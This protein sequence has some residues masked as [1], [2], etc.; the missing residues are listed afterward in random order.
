MEDGPVAGL[1]VLAGG[2]S[3]EHD[4][5]LLSAGEMLGQLRRGG[6][7]ARPVLID[8]EGRWHFGGPDED[9]AALSSAAAARRGAPRTLPAALDELQRSGE[10]AVLGLH[11]RFGEDGELQRHLEARGLRFTGSGSHASAV[12]MDKELSKVAATR[13]GVRCARHEVVTLAADPAHAVGAAGEPASARSAAGPASREARRIA[14]IVGLPCVVKPVCGG[15]SVGVTIVRDEAALA[16][17][18]EAAAAEDRAGRVL[19]EAFVDGTELTC[20]VLRLS[21]AVRC[22]PLVSIEPAGGAFYDYHAKYVAEDTRLTCPAPVPEA[23]RREIESA[24]ESLY[25]ALE[26]RGVVRVDFML[27]ASDGAPTFLEFNTL[28][29]FTSHS[30][31]PLAAAAAGISRLDVLKAILE[32]VP[33]GP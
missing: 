22:L 24:S 6:Y 14:R 16:A 3:A 29:G 17:A 1:A 20:G 33:G 21:G 13:L 27:R 31:V 26:L 19:V 12:G 8:R 5:S 7:R 4:V 10:I 23:T 15:S 2:P 30:L 18:L 32:D 11:G 25:T 28:P 9:L